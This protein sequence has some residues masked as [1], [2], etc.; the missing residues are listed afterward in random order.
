MVGLGAALVWA[1]LRRRWALAAAFVTGLAWPVFVALAA[2]LVVPSANRY[3]VFLL[4]VLA[5][6]VALALGRVSLP[7]IAAML[8]GTIVCFGAAQLTPL[9]HNPRNNPA[10]AAVADYLVNQHRT[11]VFADYTIAYVLTAQVQE[12][13]TA[14]AVIPSRNLEYA[15]LAQH[16][17]TSV[18][19]WA[20]RPND[21]AL[22]PSA[23]HRV[24]FGPY[25]VYLY[26][27]RV[28]LPALG[29]E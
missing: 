6:G 9:T 4:P 18:I 24:Q 27:G 19:V 15:R 1:V 16:A 13:I 23:A 8:A 12:R 21:A 29:V 20:G 11:R 3:V 10:L 28:A 26:P 7:V 2:P 25:A 22:R 5:L 14:E 17:S